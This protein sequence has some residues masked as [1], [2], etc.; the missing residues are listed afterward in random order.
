MS[1]NDKRPLLLLSGQSSLNQHI[2][3]K[4]QETVTKC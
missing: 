3:I 4:V 1:L 2:G